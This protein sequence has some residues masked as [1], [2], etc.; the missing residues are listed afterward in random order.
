[1]CMPSGQRGRVSTGSGGT[2]AFW[3]SVG[4]RWHGDTTFA[5]LLP[6]NSDWATQSV[7]FLYDAAQL[8]SVMMFLNASSVLLGSKAD[9]SVKGMLFI[10]AKAQVL[11]VGIAR[12][13]CMSPLWYP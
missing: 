11:S 3:V 10:S 9:I 6:G 5:T 4:G 13:W 12:R 1:M 8:I 7:I 2:E